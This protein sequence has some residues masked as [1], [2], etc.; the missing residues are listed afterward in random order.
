VILKGPGIAPGPFLFGESISA[1]M[2]FA[3]RKT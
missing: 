2:D 3:F 1:D